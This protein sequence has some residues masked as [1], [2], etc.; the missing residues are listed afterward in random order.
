MTDQSITSNPRHSHDVRD[1]EIDIGEL[2]SSVWA[3]KWRV[4]VSVTVVATLFV[5]LQAVSFL[6]D[7]S[8]VRYSQEFDLTFEGLSDGEFPD[9]SEFVLSDI[10]S[11]TVLTRVYNRNNLE[12]QD[13]SLDQFR[14][15]FTIE[16]FSPEYFLI[17]QRYR[18]EADSQNLSAAELQAL[19]DRL[20]EELSLANSGGVRISM[21][22]PE[23]TAISETL[24]SKLLLDVAS[25]W[26]DRAINERGVL[27]LNI[28]IYSERIFDE[29]RFENLD[30]LLGIEL[31]LENI[32]L[33]TGNVEA[34]K[35]VP[36]STSIVDDETG[37]NLEDLE[38]AIMD[39]ADYDL[40]QLIDPVKELGLT[41][42]EAVVRLYYTR[43]L[44]ELE[45]QLNLWEQ[46]A[47]VTR[48]VMQ[49]F[50]QDSSQSQPGSNGQGQG[51]LQLGDGFLDRLLEVSRQGSDVEFR[52]SLTELVL[53]YENEALDIN[54]EM[55]EIQLTLNAIS[56]TGAN[57]ENELREL[58]I[59]EVQEKLPSV[60]NTLRD[61]TRVVG[62]LHE[63][64]GEQ[65]T[66]NIS[67]LI[68]PQGGSFNIATPSILPQRTLLILVAL[69]VVTGFA[70]MVISLIA[71]MMK[72]RKMAGA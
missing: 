60:L 51:S 50:A 64:L 19:Q 71:D 17:Q 42:N 29:Q 7:S 39:V 44:Q 32:S 57:S 35:E 68:I 26:A 1:D 22:L 67:Q 27:K 70:A 16:P 20:T 24:A 10:I 45:L 14:R 54:Q 55:A 31:L 38:K 43:R 53:E 63:R 58:Y 69:M 37:Y 65:L 2:I 21:S 48:S 61:Y 36:G 56:N 4:L 23:Q 30:Y 46:R 34:L 66:G 12:Q 11:P 49:Q 62:R 25:V 33:I 52:Q 18:A 41:R 15:A 59:Q 6:R 5:V 28:P 9:G 13:M 47:E 40:R 3:T 8:T 72:R